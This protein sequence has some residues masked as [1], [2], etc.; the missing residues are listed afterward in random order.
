MCIIHIKFLFLF[1][2]EARA[3]IVGG[4]EKFYK[5]GSS[6][7]LRCDLSGVEEPEFVF[8][9]Q[10]SDASQICKKRFMRMY[11]S[12][13]W[14]KV[15]L[16]SSLPLDC[17]PNVNLSLECKKRRQGA[18]SSSFLYREKKNEGNVCVCVPCSLV[19][20]K[21]H[22]VAR[23]TYAKPYANHTSFY[24]PFFP[25]SL[26]SSYI[27]PPLFLYSLQFFLTVITAIYVIALCRQPKKKKTEAV[28]P[29]VI[30]NKESGT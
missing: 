26:T 7:E 15:L 19:L 2:A 10:A 25:S 3:E 20:T 27:Y 23:N 18:L 28:L 11:S 6:V 24:C 13:I 9:Y 21:F 12:F 1:C 8:W 14:N 30:V 17:E 29:P 4:P 16:P 22:K 5:A